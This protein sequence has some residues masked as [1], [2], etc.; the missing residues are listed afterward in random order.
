[1][2]FDPADHLRGGLRS[3]NWRS[4]DL[5]VASFAI[6]GNLN[7]DEIDH[8]TSGRRAPSRLEYNVLAAAL[9]DHLADVGGGPSVPYWRD[10][11]PNGL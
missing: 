6:G 7:A 1:M 5:W 3:A 2:T 8:I 4:S 11:P 9:N 10:L